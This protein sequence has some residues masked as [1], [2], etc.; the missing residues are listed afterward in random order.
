MHY[1]VLKEVDGVNGFDLCSKC[2]ILGNNN[3]DKNCLKVLLQ[4]NWKHIS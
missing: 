1:L 3:I 4:V 2:V